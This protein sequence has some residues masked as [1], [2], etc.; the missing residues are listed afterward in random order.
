MD[1][2]DACDVAGINEHLRAWARPGEFVR[3]IA[4]ERVAM[5]EDALDALVETVEQFAGGGK[6]L[7]VCDHAPMKRAGEDLKPLVLDRLSRRVAVQLR[8]MP[9]KPGPCHAKMEAARELAAE[10]ADYTVLVSVGSG[11]ITDVAK[12]ARHLFVEANPKARMRFVSFPTAAS[13]TAFTSALAVLSVDGVKRTISSRA[14]DAV[15]CDLRTIA[16]A[17]AAM[18]QAGFG[19]VMA[20]SVAYGDYFLA[21]AVGMDD[22]FSLLPGRLLAT[23]EQEMIDRADD[24]AEA[25]VPGVRAVTEAV[26]LAGMAMS[27]VNQTAP[28]SGWEHVI[29]HFFDMTAAYDRR[30]QAL[31]GGQVGVATLVAARAYERVWKNMDLERIAADPAPDAAANARRRI[32]TTFAKYDSKGALIQELWR[33]YEKKL[34]RWQQAGEARRRFTAAKRAGEFDAFI[35]ANVRSSGAIAESLAQA[36]A[37]LTFGALDQPVPL[38]T[39]HAAVESSHLIRA[40]FTLGDLLDQSGWLNATTARALLDR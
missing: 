29:S 24:V 25:A 35:A 22:D 26:L 13:V 4:I 15:I 12:Y 9:S 31:H 37:P 21:H 20:R 28:I 38:E 2:I 14:P 10:L 36:G 27:I 17:P 23:A 34:N 8:H 7:M 1:R 3:P 6:V 39:A 32:E 33:D 18:T 11:T 40:R 5:A 16:D 30:E 19:D